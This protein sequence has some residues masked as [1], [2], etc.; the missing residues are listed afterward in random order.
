MPSP[1]WAPI[2]VL[3]YCDCIFQTGNCKEAD[4]ALAI[5]YPWE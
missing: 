1:K 4:L 5:Y 3:G 2:N